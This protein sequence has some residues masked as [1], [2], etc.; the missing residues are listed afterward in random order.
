MSNDFEESKLPHFTTSSSIITTNKNIN[1][2]HNIDEIWFRR[3][4]I[5]NLIALPLVSFFNIVY[6]ISI[7]FFRVN[8]VTQLSLYYTEYAIFQAY[9]TIDTLW[10]LLK[11]NSV[12]SASSILPHHI[13]SM[14]GWN[15]PF[16]FDIKYSFL[17]SIGILVEMNTFFLILRRNCNKNII[18]EFLFYA[19]W[20]TIRCG[21]YPY[22]LLQT[23]WEYMN[24]CKYSM[25]IW[26]HELLIFLVVL[27]LTIL[28]GKWTIDLISKFI[29]KDNDKKNHSL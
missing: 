22:Y 13:I 11:P 28:N 20:F 3:H 21:V 8:H 4:D 18:I 6:L 29:K 2:R 16:I 19:S 27:V 17:M 5:F 25:K 23:A 15:T 26:H 24:V 7:I 9:L 10:L 14:F 1:S 12:A